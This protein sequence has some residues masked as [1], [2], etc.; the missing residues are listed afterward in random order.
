MLSV[1]WPTLIRKPGDA[2]A[3]PFDTGIGA[4][5]GE[6]HHEQSGCDHFQR[7]RPEIPKAKH[8]LIP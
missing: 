8:L 1:G 4:K 6:I 3:Q 5:N 2:F 7:R